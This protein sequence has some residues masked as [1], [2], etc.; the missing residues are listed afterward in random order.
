MVDVSIP[1]TMIEP[2]LRFGGIMHAAR[3]LW[4]IDSTFGIA[5]FAPDYLDEQIGTYAK[6][7]NSFLTRKIGSIKGAPNILLIREPKETGSQGYESLLR[8]ESSSLTYEKELIEV[9]NSEKWDNILVFPG[10][11]DLNLCW[12]HICNCEAKLYIDVNFEPQDWSFFKA[13]DKKIE[14]IIL[15][16][17]SDYFLK[18]MKGETSKLLESSKNTSCNSLLFKENRGGSR[19]F[20][21]ESLSRQI[22][23][24]AQLSSISHSVGVGDCYN[25]IFASMRHQMSDQEALSFASCVSAEYASTTCPDEFQRNVSSWR[26]IPI[27]DIIQLKGVSI[28]WEKRPDFQ[29]YIAGPDFNFVNTKPIDR[30]V[31]SLKYHNFTPRLPVRENGQM[32]EKASHSLKKSLCCKDIELLTKCS[33]LIAVMLYHD[34]GTLIEIGIAIEKGIPVVVYEPF[35]HSDNLML[36]ELPKLVTSDIDEVIM[37]VFTEASNAIKS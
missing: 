7:F 6:S 34:P 35:E 1:K 13:F 29:I 23:I 8:Y 32:G 2:K 5:Y 16:T 25:A 28:A 9:L 22:Q 30:I 19:F 24:P 15:S 33:M 4:S 18:E 20:Y 31:E 10:G 14:T 37:S 26:K 12:K 36:T 21:G 17:S 27:K 11:F 3:A